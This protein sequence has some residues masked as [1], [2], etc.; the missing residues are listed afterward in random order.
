MGYAVWQPRHLQPWVDRFWYSEGTLEHQRERLLPAP[1]IELVVNL[2]PPMRVIEGRGTEIL[3]GG[4]TSG[5]AMTPQVLEH[6]LVHA[7]VAVRLHP[8][9]ASALFVQSLAPWTDHF[10]TLEELVGVAP[11]AELAER[12]FAAATAQ[13]RMEELARWVEARLVRVEIDPVVAW[14]ARQIEVTHGGAE[15]AQLRDKAGVSKTRFVDAFRHAV[16]VKPKMYARITR[17]AR[18]LSLLDA[19]PRSLAAVAAAAGYYDQPHMN[20]E[21]RALAGLSPQKLAGTRYPG[22]FTIAED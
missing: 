22:G 6:P 20:G 19:R 10:V 2:G 8:V 7:A 1:S 16:G 18:A 15:M 9:A 11:A 4:V 21:F 12:C 13:A 3:R 5:L 14:T 17:F